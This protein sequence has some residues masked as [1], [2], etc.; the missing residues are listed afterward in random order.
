MP[1]KR[2][3]AQFIGS[4]ERKAL[5]SRISTHR[6]VVSMCE[7]GGDQV[8]REAMDSI[9]AGFT[10]TTSKGT[11][12]NEWFTQELLAMQSTLDSFPAAVFMRK[13]ISSLV[14]TSI[15]VVIVS[16]GTESDSYGPIFGSLWEFGSAGRGKIARPHLAPLSRAVSSVG[17]GT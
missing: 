9:E 4:R 5:N 16:Y 3:G 17:K 2:A 14:G 11:G 15:P 6:K 7:R 10:M 13:K 8:K 1:A 12:L